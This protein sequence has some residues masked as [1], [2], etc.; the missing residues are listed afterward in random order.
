MP[1]FENSVDP[2]ANQLASNEVMKLANF[3]TLI[4]AILLIWWNSQIQN[5]KGLFDVTGLI[6]SNV[7]EIITNIS[8]Y[9][10][11]SCPLPDY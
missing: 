1:D 4:R 5:V 6:R 8:Y 10:G 9:A 11:F 3:C 2:A 7:S